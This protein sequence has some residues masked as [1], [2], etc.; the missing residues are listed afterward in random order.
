[1]ERVVI[2]G[3]STGIGWSATRDLCRRGLHV[4]GSVRRL[5]DAD[6]LREEFPDRFTPLVFDVTDGDA[7]AR[8]VLEVEAAL[9]GDGLLGLVNN[10][11]ISVSGPLAL[12]PI[13]GLRH[14]FEVNVLG[15]VRV[16][17]AF[18]PLL[19]RT[20]RERGRPGRVVNVSSL[21][22]RI[23]Y[24][25]M[26]PYAA[27]THALEALSDALRRELWIYGVDVVVIQP[28]SILT[29][30]WD[31]GS[32]LSRAFRGSDYGPILRRI[33]LEVAKREALPPTAADRAIRR[34]L[35]S[36]RPRSRYVIPHRWI[37]YWIG[38]RL[39]PDRWLDRI[40]ARIL[41]LPDLRDRPPG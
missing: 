31:K 38:P 5:E 13:D 15:V 17:Q 25:F 7:I 1:M 21:S 3:V 16:T 39:L 4:F 32:D 41:R 11:G 37:K 23:A 22:G 20:G 8:A 24:P 36:R 14:Q 30:I 35:T 18:L 12:V 6:A 40:I 9:G 33:N 27:S 29:P 2:T 26:G 19:R 28:G 10:A 34:A